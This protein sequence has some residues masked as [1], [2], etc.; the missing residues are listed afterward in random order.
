MSSARRMTRSLWQAR[1][2]G[3]VF[4]SR[5]GGVKAETAASQAEEGTQH[6]SKDQ[7][8]LPSAA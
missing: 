3:W 4:D 5:R 7:I 2:P 6:Y 1:L 8:A